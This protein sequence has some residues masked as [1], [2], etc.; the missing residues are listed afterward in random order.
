VVLRLMLVQCSAV[1]PA[2]LEEEGKLL[3]LP[4]FEN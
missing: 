2:R 4:S 1:Q 3:Q